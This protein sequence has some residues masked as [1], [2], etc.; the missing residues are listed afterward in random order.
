MTFQ[1]IRILN[2]PFLVIILITLLQNISNFQ[3]EMT[4]NEKYQI[5]NNQHQS[6]L[7]ILNETKLQTFDE[8]YHIMTIEVCIGVPKQCFNLL[9]DTGMMYTII[10]DNSTKVSF[11]NKYVPSLS[12]SYRSKS[13]TLYTFAYRYGQINA[14]EVCDYCVLDEK[15]PPYTFNFLVAYNTTT[16]YNFDG[17]LGLGHQ[18][19]M[20]EEGVAFD[21][22]FSFMEYLKFNKVIKKKVF[23]HEYLNRTYGKFYFDEVPKSMGN[24]YHKCQAQFNIPF[25]YKWYCD[26]ISASLSSGKVFSEIQSPVAFDTGYIDVRGPLQEGLVLLNE[27]LSISGGRCNIEEIKIGEK[28]T[29]KKLI[30]QENV[31]ISSFPNIQFNINSFKGNSQMVLL[32]DDMFRLV[33]V[34]GVRKYVCKVILDSRYKYWN[35]GEPVL[36]NYDMIFDGEESFVGFKENVNFYGESMVTVIILAIVLVGVIAFGVWVYINRKKL[37]AKSLSQAEIEKLNSKE[38]FDEGN[39][40]GEIK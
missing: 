24:D 19:P 5:K 30:C 17:I 37:F 11:T 34:N 12:Q 23:A 14:R 20:R 9:Y 21:E 6:R 40:L 22:R 13:Q 7:R 39:Q 10:G 27:L 35:L 25:L 38:A 8:I 15:R 1:K 18:Y 28:D 36:K 33:E 31:K 26:I 16:T 32:T 3:Y 2:S 4:S 29:M